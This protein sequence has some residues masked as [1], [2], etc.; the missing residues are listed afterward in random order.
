M[1]NVRWKEGAGGE[2]VGK[3]CSQKPMRARNRQVR[4]WRVRRRREGGL[5]GLEGVRKGVVVAAAR[6]GDE[7]GEFGVGVRMLSTQM[8]RGADEDVSDAMAGME[9]CFMLFC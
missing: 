9:A 5:E 4:A 2:G 8:L 6:D 1:R 3:V 7:D